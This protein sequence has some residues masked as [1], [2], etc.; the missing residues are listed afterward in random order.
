M[1]GGDYIYRHIIASCVPGLVYLLPNEL[2][3]CFE[4]DNNF[5]SFTVKEIYSGTVHEGDRNEY[6]YMSLENAF[7]EAC[8]TIGP[9]QFIL[10]VDG[11][12]IAIYVEESKF[13]VFDPHSRNSNGLP[14]PE[15]ASVLGVVQTLQLACSFIRTLYQKSPGNLNTK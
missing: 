2:P 14:C 9:F 6:P 13:Y 15:G 8:T 11:N 7:T 3:E 5:Y 4:Y 12:A 10:I 1:Y